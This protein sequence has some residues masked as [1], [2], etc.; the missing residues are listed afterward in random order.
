MVT[1][2]DHIFVPIGS[3]QNQKRMLCFKQFRTRLR[4]CGTNHSSFSE[5][6]LRPCV[7]RPQGHSKSQ[8][9]AVQTTKTEQY[10]LYPFDKSPAAPHLPALYTML[11]S[12]KKYHGLV[13][14]LCNYVHW[15]T[16]RCEISIWKQAHLGADI[17]GPSKMLSFRGGNFD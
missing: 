8:R 4:M 10:A 11:D 3:S 9:A 13:T 12:D 14:R 1:M 5:S 6:I 17:I 15:L 16:Y 7:S 2:R